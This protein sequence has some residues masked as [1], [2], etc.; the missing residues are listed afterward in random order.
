MKGWSPTHASGAAAVAVG[1]DVHGTVLANPTIIVQSHTGSAGHPGPARL[2]P[3]PSSDFTGRE[4][5]LLEIAAAL[6]R[7]DEQVC[8]V[9]VIVGKPGV[10]KTA[11]ALRFAHSGTAEYVHGELYADLR[12]VDEHPVPATEIMARFLLV[13]GIPEQALPS[14]PAALA[15]IYRQV[16]ATRSVLVVLDNAADEKQVRPLLP[17]G[18]GSAVLVTSRNQLGGLE[19]SL[20]VD[21]QT[22]PAEV[23]MEFLQSVLGPRALERDRKHA[24]EVVEYCGGLPLALR[25]CANRLSSTRNLRLSDLAR[26]LRDERTRLEALHVGDLAVRAAFNLSY[27]ELGKAAA[28]AFRY[29]ALVPG[30][31]FGQGICGALTGSD[32]GR[33][34][35][36]LEKLATA[37][38]IEP[39]TLYGRFRFHD[40]LKAYAAEQLRRDHIDRVNAGAKGMTRW[41]TGSAMAAYSRLAGQ[42]NAVAMSDDSHAAFPTVEDAS[43]WA[44]AEL[45]SAVAT[46][47]LLSERG[48]LQEAASLTLSLSLVCEALGRWREW[49]EVVEVGLPATH[50]LGMPL[51][52]PMVIASKANLARARREFPK[53]LGIAR[54]AYALAGT[55]GDP[56][57][58][59]TTA[60]ML[61]CLC[62]DNGLHQEGV[63]LLEQSLALHQA[64]GRT[65]AIAMVLYNLGTLYR[66]A[67]ETEKAIAA[68]EQ[69][70]RVCHEFGDEFGEAESLNT[71]A[72]THLDLDQ[73]EIAEPHQRRALEIFR[74][75]GNP[76]KESMVSND[77]GL[78]LRLLGRYEDALEL[79]ERDIELC[80]A[81]ENDSDE[82]L[83]QANAAEVLHL[84]GRN[85]RAAEVSLLAVATLT[86]LGDGQRLARSLIGRIPI[87][88]EDGRKDEALAAADRA[89]TILEARGETRDV[90]SAHQALALGYA[91][92]GDYERSLHHAEL[93]LDLYGAVPPLRFSSLSHLLA[94]EAA[95]A[96]DEEKKARHFTTGPRAGG[97][98][99]M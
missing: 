86:R 60:N 98:S 15:D 45:P 82:A 40:L 49:E 34:R 1:G 89:I 91:G 35:K 80:R 9:I 36:S 12:G 99:A 13:L 59:A 3:S 5:E 66:A 76:H 75:I 74:S 7:T 16:L 39:S 25:I 65:H 30:E 90:G 23:S 81:V 63:E 68:F 64:L 8:P 37:S 77:L 14:N 57:M 28:K 4:N 50:K 94:V 93:S 20:R 22:L 17:A 72:L 69:D 53:A 52:E 6:A 21:L 19:S 85:D 32:E 70:V 10:G 95:Q 31:D 47:R 79:H 78:T 56:T 44:A 18:A 38:L 41:L 11:L 24:A 67:G 61:G 26:E 71:L 92:M 27:R 54:E 29:L 58:I 33:A 73:P 96:L 51:I 97:G 62:M 42:H 83:A 46:L 88:F 2:L 55:V 87:L 48:A 43:A 84:L